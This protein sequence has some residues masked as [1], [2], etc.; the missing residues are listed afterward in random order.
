MINKEITRAIDMIGQAKHV[1]AFTGAG[2]SVESGIP[3]FRGEGGL[4][5]QY[6]PQILD[7]DYFRQHPKASW[8]VI[9]EIF[10]DFFGQAKPN[11]AH[12]TLG[13]MEQQG[14]L[15]EVI[16]QNI[17]SLHQEGGSKRVHEFH[18]SSRTLVC[19]QCNQR[20][21]V[22]E[23]NLNQ[24]I[25]TCSSCGGTLK[26]DFIFFGEGIPAAAYEASVDAAQKADLFIVIG[27]TGEVMPACQI[28][29]MAKEQGCKIIEINP[30]LSAFTPHITDIF[31]PGK[32]TVIMEAI[33]AGLSLS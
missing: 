17:D 4:W 23:V 15:R 28:P 12:I 33:A 14:M 31:L 10:Y 19:M 18:G 24:P 1:T 16:T 22:E 20:H 21:A 9:K 8:R 26:P 3:P 27:T 5:S 13:M 2:I 11:S 29:Y 7:L 32:A 30:T 6:D 25:P